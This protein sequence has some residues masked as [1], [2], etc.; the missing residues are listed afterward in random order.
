MGAPD[1]ALREL[2]DELATAGQTHDTREARHARR[3]LNLEAD[4]AQLVSILVAS[5][6]RTRILEL[7]TS[8]GYSAI[9]LAHAIR[10]SGGRLISIERDAE[11]WREADVNLRRAGLRESVELLLGDATPL[12]GTLRGPFDCIFFNADR[13]RY[14]EQLALLLP[15]LT[16]DCLLL[17]D[18]ALSHPDEIAPYLT[19]VA[20]LP[21]FAHVV[22]P[23]GKGLS[24][25]YRVAP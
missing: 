22:A 5:G 24:I 18:N 23:T 6:R 10:S 2:L 16:P 17:A 1:P 12:I 8:N 14:P 4:T 15:K 9:W 20:A 7:G 11:K 3:R 21:D 13:Q 19:A 25:A